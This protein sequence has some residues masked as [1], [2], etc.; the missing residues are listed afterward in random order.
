MDVAHQVSL[1][2]GFSR[3]K[4]WSGLPFPPPEDLPDPGMQ[5]SCVSCIS[6]Q[7]FFFFLPLVSPGKPFRSLGV[8]QLKPFG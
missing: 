5:V 4:Y 1:S 8:L 6:R 2:M 7:V 3:K